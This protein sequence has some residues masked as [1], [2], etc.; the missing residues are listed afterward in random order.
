MRKYI[1]HIAFFWIYLLSAISC[2]ET[3]SV[4]DMT[5]YEGPVLELSDIESYYSDSAVVRIKMVA[6]KQL[7]FE[8]NDSEFPEGL[9]LEFYDKNG[10]LSSTLEASYAYK[11]N[12]ED[13]W[14][15]LRNVIVKNIENNE[16]LHTEELFW[17]PQKEL[18]YTNKFVRIETEDQILMG[19]GMEASQDFSWW[20]ILDARGTISLDEENQ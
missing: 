11:Y 8:N 2:S 9:Y 20:R 3:R 6:P 17:E 7:E 15:A 5:L 14:R 10:T 1:T 13:K 4:D 19:E 18:V 16:E 12:K